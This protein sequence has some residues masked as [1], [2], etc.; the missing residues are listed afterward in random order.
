[1]EDAKVLTSRRIGTQHVVVEE[2]AAQQHARHAHECVQQ[3]ATGHHDVK[4]EG[5]DDF[6]RAIPAEYDGI[7]D[8]GRSSNDTGLEPSARPQL[9]VELDVECKQ[10]HQWHQRL[11]DDPQNHVVIHGAAVRQF[12]AATETTQ[13]GEYAQPGGEDY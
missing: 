13:K 12:F 8:E 9:P 7:K 10:Q 2:L 3:N 11:A 5:R 1:Q 6:L 4:S